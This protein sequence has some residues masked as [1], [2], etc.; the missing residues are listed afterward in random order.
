MSRFETAVS[1]I[2]RRTEHEAEKISRVVGWWLFEEA[3]RTSDNNAYLDDFSAFREGLDAH[4]GPSQ[5]GPAKAGSH[6]SR[7]ISWT[8]QVKEAENELSEEDYDYLLA[9]QLFGVLML[10]SGNLRTQ[11]LLVSSTQQE[12]TKYRRESMHVGAD[13]RSIVRDRVWWHRAVKETSSLEIEQQRLLEDTLAV[14]DVGRMWTG[15]F[16]YTRGKHEAGRRDTE[17]HI[18]GHI[19]E[20]AWIELAVD[21]I[22]YMDT[23]HFMKGRVSGYDGFASVPLLEPKSITL[24]PAII[25]PF[26]AAFPARAEV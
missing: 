19:A 6:H 23:R 17:T 1:N 25:Y 7:L 22:F 20:Q 11:A 16:V 14:N 24:E 21:Y 8:H 9:R 26:S 18:A 2:E 15:E 5:I 3:N 4:S 12:Y 10:L 13:L